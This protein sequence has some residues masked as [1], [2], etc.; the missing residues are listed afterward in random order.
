MQK[1]HNIRTTHTH[2]ILHFTPSS[3][4]FT[5]VRHSMTSPIFIGEYY[6]HHSR[7]KF[8]RSLV[9]SLYSSSTKLADNNNNLVDVIIFACASLLSSLMEPPHVPGWW[10]WRKNDKFETV[11]SKLCL[12]MFVT[13]HLSFN[14]HSQVAASSSYSSF[15]SSSVA[16]LQSTRLERQQGLWFPENPLSIL[17]TSSSILVA[18]FVLNRFRI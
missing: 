18:N 13:G 14:P 2:S 12:C 3:I 15:S 10:W 5:H 4:L 16:L 1:C 11:H 7:F 6:C 8:A 9:G 17:F